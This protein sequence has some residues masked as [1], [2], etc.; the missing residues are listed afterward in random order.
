M[1]HELFKISI[2][3]L[4]D[5]ELETE[6]VS[7]LYSNS[8]KLIA[9]P[10]AEM[11]VDAI[12]DNGNPPESPLAHSTGSG[13]PEESKGGKRGGA[14]RDALS[15]TDLNLPDTVSIRFAVSALTDNRLKNRHTGVDTLQSLI[16]LCAR[17]GKSVLFFGGNVETLKLAKKKVEGSLPQTLLRE[18]MGPVITSTQYQGRDRDGFSISILDPGA[19]ELVDD[20]VVIESSMMNRI[21]KIKPDVIAIALPHKKQLA[22]M[23]QF[24]DEFPSVKIMI[25]V[26]G[27]LDMISGRLKRAPKWMRRTG[28]EWLWRVFTYFE[29]EPIRR[30]PVNR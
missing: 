25:G 4:N 22:F 23:R 15:N 1:K 12:Q 21:N 29:W 18:E 2:D 20:G 28:L 24:K 3:D 10:N 8:T 14:F 9:T 27:A 5:A 6:L 26:G 30:S 11:L 16:E 17:E 19:V 7:F 13:H